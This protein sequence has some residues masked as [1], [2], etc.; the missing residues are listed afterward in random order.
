VVL[1]L[2]RAEVSAASY[3]PV[4]WGDEN[5]GQLGNGEFGGFHITPVAV[6]KLGEEV[7]IGDEVAVGDESMALAAGYEHALSLLRNGKVMAWGESGY[8]QLGDGASRGPETCVQFSEC[9]TV[10][11]EVTGLHE[12]TAIAAGYYFSLALSSSGKVMAWGDGGQG[13]LG[14]GSEFVRYVPVQ[15]TGLSEATAIAGGGFH[16]LALMKNGT[17][18]AW[19]AN[20]Y[21]QL[22]DGDETKSDVPVEV[23]GLH[24]VTAIAAGLYSSLALL[25]NGTVMAWGENTSGQLGDGSETNSDIPVEVKGLHE[26]AAIASDGS[27][28]LALLKDGRV[29]AWGDNNAGQLGDGSETNSEVPVEVQGLSGATAIAAG[30]QHSLALLG[31]GEIMAW[32]D[33]GWGEL[34]N[35]NRGNTD[36]PVQ[37]SG[38]SEVTAIAAG[39]YSSYAEQGAIGEIVGAVTS[40]ATSDP[41]E[42]AKVCA[43]SSSGPGRWRCATTDATGEYVITL[44]ESATYDVKFSAPPGSGYLASEYYDGKPSPSEETAVPVT[45]GA[46]TS[47][48]DAQLAEGGRITGTVTSAPAK[49]PL[50]G[51][52]VCALE[53]SAECVLTNANGEYTISGLAAGGYRVEFFTSDGMYLPQYWNRKR[54]ASEG[55]PVPVTLG[56]TTSEID[57]ELE[58]LKSGAI[59]GDVR[60][61][62]TMQGIKGIEVCAY[63]ASVEESGLEEGGLEENG[64]FARCAETNARGEYAI[65]ELTTGEYLVEFSSPLYGSLN[66]VTQ[67]FNASSSAQGATIVQV[68]TRS[69]VAGIDAQLIEGGRIAGR[70]TN[71]STTGPIAGIEVCAY[72]TSGEGFGCALT[73][74]HGEYAVSALGNGD[75]DVEFSAPRESG[76]D[77]VTQYYDH[78][79]MGSVADPVAATEG[80]TTSGIDAQLEEGGRIEGAVTDAS[81]NAAIA[82]VL[83]CARVSSGKSAGCGLTN[84]TGDYSITGLAGGQ[85][86]VGFDA[87]KRYVLQYYSDKLSLSEAQAVPV[88]AGATTA[89]IDAALDPS[90][91]IPPANTKSPVILGGPAIGEALL[92]ADG[93]WAGSPTPSLTDRW[94]RDGAPI[95]GATSGSYTVQSADAGHAL[96]CEV[97]ARSSAGERS[98][99]SAGLAIAGS[100]TGAG[101]AATGPSTARG[102]GRFKRHDLKSPIAVKASTLT[103]S[104]GVA[105]VRVQCR[106]EHCAGTVELT[107]RAP[108]RRRTAGRTVSHAALLVLARG[109][110]AFP[111]KSGSA[112]IVLRLTPAGRRRLARASKRNPVAAQ[113]SVMAPGVESVVVKSVLV[114]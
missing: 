73:G 106:G 11:V 50:A 6:G 4:A 91:A 32:G 69:V 55:Q 49:A 54:S 65:L 39:G 93:L 25:R 1:W 29:M 88:T 36:L 3:G 60:D 7:A 71:A 61:S 58:P 16:S 94:L 89:G 28:S 86:T 8:G 84:A 41:I 101:T 99:V 92:C 44:H 98:A 22:G 21:G 47:G 43:T 114:T 109:Q 103:V 45:L 59:T 24:E 17:V 46:T 64:L 66:Y 80:T 57:A 52:E 87:G 40:A 2:G 82:N 102:A 5:Y 63:E 19:G 74:A 75:Y 97:T 113:L 70:V 83:V 112:G 35:S 108:T 31:S 26:V 81:T 27:H 20:E 10:P 42:G 34:G 38:P 37:V 72:S 18:M 111:G 56:E 15:V 68:G 12:T 62:T 13:Q 110:L 77:Y 95:S 79:R 30:V 85:Y 107:M 90:D 104:G 96:A 76:L 105:R 14:D 9:S 67:Y 33:N 53:S 78:E 48:I 100:P 23:Q 51:A